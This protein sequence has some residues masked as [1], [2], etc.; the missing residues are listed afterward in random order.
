MNEEFY[1]GHQGAMYIEQQDS[2]LFKDE[3]ISVFSVDQHTAKQDTS[4][5][6]GSLK[7]EHKEHFI[8]KAHIIKLNDTDSLNK[9]VEEM[10]QQE[11]KEVFHLNQVY[12]EL[13]F[14]IKLLEKKV[15]N[16]FLLKTIII[17]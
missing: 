10:K 6:L 11:R 7:T 8:N 5:Y 17:F 16:K 13:D 3:G 2:E 15:S 9:Q 4:K 14:K 1:A 12:T